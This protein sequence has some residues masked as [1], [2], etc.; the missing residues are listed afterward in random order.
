[1]YLYNIV[2][3]LEPTRSRS[4]QFLPAP[5]PALQCSSR[6]VP[7]P[8]SPA[9]SSSGEPVDQLE[10]EDLEVCWLACKKDKQLGIGWD[11]DMGPALQ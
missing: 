3:I 6:V 1:M 7:R 11:W 5:A 2:T 8:W 10:E 9:A 4:S